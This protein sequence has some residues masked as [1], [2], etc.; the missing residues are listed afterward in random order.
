MID[1]FLKAF[2]VAK[3]KQDKADRGVGDDAKEQFNQRL[4]SN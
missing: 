3:A 4:C 1:G 2:N